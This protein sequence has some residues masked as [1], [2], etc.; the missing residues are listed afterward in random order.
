MKPQRSNATG[1]SRATSLDSAVS[2]KA[3]GIPKCEERRLICAW[4]RSVIDA[5]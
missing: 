2:S 4:Q 3:H 5:D 1:K